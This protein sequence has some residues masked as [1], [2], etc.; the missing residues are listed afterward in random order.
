MESV[1]FTTVIGDDGVIRAPS[2]TILPQG[3]V[4]VVVRSHER[5]P[6]ERN[7]DPTFGWL[8]PMARAAEASSTRLPADLAQQH[9]H[10]AHGKPKS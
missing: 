2:G 6:G 8:L 10:Y 4:Q 1:E 5:S 7:D 9:D 3:A